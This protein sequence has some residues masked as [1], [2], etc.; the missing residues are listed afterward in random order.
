MEA[1]EIAAW[2]FFNRAWSACHLPFCLGELHLK[3]AW[4]DLRQQIPLA[5]ELPFLIGDLDEL[6]TD[7]SADGD[8]VEGGD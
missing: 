3:G 1:L 8:H 2:T 6:S 7:P 4:I 5:D